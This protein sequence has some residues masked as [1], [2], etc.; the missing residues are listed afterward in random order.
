MSV[1]DD[2]TLDRYATAIVHSCL[3]VHDDDLLA[4]HGEPAHRELILALTR[5][6]Y[7]AG[8][9]YVDVQFVEPLAAQL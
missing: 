8:A 7:A 6:A 4:I 9:R 3:A 2:R 1:L 5:V